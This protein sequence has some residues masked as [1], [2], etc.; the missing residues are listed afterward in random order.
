MTDKNK[1]KNLERISRSIEFSLDEFKK[2]ASKK[3]IEI[4]ESP[5]VILNDFGYALAFRAITRYTEYK[6]NQ[7]YA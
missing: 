4:I 1:T 2:F 6:K 5:H 3:E 7:I